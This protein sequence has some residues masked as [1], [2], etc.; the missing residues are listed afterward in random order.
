MA[1]SKI[2]NLTAALT[3]LDGTEQVAIVQ[4]GVTKVATVADTSSLTNVLNIG[5]TTSGNN[6]TLSSGDILNLTDTSNGLYETGGEVILYSG[7]T[8]GLYS[9]ASS[10][11]SFFSGYLNPQKGHKFIVA[12]INLLQPF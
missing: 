1:D 3:P 8:I 12:I 9:G 11:A 2:S 5:N 4:S 10:S 7:G 6:I